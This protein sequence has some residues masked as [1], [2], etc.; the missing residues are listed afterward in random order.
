MVFGGENVT[1]NKAVPTVVET[2]HFKFVGTY[3]AAVGLEGVYVLDAAGKSFVSSVSDVQP[4]NAYIQPKDG[5]PAN[6]RINIFFEDDFATSI[7][8]VRTDDATTNNVYDL[9]GRKVS[10]NGI[11]ALPKGIYILNGK[12]VMK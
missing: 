3:V 12:K 5:V 1:V 7:K 11:D 9:Q 6:A 4:F 8:G 10:E 2:D